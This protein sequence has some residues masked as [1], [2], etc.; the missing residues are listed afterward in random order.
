MFHYDIFVFYACFDI[1]LS[2]CLWNSRC[3]AV[4]QNIKTSSNTVAMWTKFFPRAVNY[5]TLPDI[6]ENGLAFG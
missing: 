5:D 6:Q 1:F 3:A 4:N 2:I